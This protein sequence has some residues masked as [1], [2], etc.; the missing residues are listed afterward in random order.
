MYQPKT[1][2]RQQRVTYS[3]GKHSTIDSDT[4]HSDDRY[5][6]DDQRRESEYLDFFLYLSHPRQDREVEPDKDRVY[7]KYRSP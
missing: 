7:R 2:N 5:H 1:Q 3:Q 4:Q 6:D